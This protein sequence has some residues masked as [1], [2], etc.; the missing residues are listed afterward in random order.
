[1]RFSKLIDA[2][3]LRTMPGTSE[4]SVSATALSSFCLCVY[5]KCS[6]V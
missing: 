6:A 3:A 2:K 1:M 4:L 5:F